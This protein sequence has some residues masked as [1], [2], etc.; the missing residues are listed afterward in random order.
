MH[1]L[2][3][4]FPAAFLSKLSNGLASALIAVLCVALVGCAKN[5][6]PTPELPT[7]VVQKMPNITYNAQT[8]TYTTTLKV[9]AYNVEGLP[10]PLRTGRGKYLKK[11]GAG[12]AKLRERG[13][14]PD[15]VL[16]QEGFMDSTLDLINTAGY[17]NVVAGPKRK[18][19]PPKINN[20]RTAS[21]EKGLYSFK[22]E[23]WGKAYHSGLYILSN[24]PLTSRHVW[25]FRHCAGWDCLSNKGVMATEVRIPGLPQPL[26][27][28]NVHMQAG[29]AS[30]VPLERSTQAHK[31][32]I[33]ETRQFFRR[34]PLNGEPFIFGGDF[35]IRNKEDRLLHGLRAMR[36]A[37]PTM[38]A[39][40]YCTKVNLTCDIDMKMPSQ[41]EPWR[42]TQDLQGFVH[43]NHIQISVIRLEA[44]FDGADQNNPQ[45]SDH[46][47]YM[48]TYKLS[49]RQ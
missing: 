43:G 6:L 27:V 44:V 47:G 4:Y 48:V 15:I 28:A 31:L 24:Y 41:E 3:P 17:R 35:N 22:G 46:D 42:H 29:G 38:L 18:E 16:I 30:G 45:L 39:R 40:H 13:L 33:D 1:S 25:G 19:R 23:G 12:L 49:W 8:N 14:E 10:F 36:V 2:T 37:E 21:F 11:I 32:Q 26:M 20:A 34:L 7:R 9:L 5:V